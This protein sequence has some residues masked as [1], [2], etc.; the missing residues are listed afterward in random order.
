MF[1]RAYQTRLCMV[2]CFSFF[3]KK[4]QYFSLTFI[5][6]DKKL[7]VDSFARLF[8]RAFQRELTDG[9]CAHFWAFANAP[10][11]WNFVD[12]SRMYNYNLTRLFELFDKNKV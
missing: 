6:P 4:K 5:C 7:Q 12:F 11:A 1:V 9:L 10:R 8:E 2:E 3:K